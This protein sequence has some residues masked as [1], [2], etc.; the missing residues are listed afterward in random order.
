MND[1]LREELLSMQQEDQRLLKKLLDCGE[2]GETEYHPQMK[3]LHEKNN[4]R[5][6]AIISEHGWPGFSIVG[7]DG[8]KAAWLIVQ[9]AVL[10]K[11]F[12]ESTLPLLKQAVDKGEAE[13]WCLAYLQ[14]RVLTLSGKPQIYGSQHDFDENGMAYPLPIAEPEKVDTLRKGLGLG[15]LSEATKSI[16]ERYRPITD[17]HR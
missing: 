16:Q 11:A 5:I 15:P 10:D 1:L 13:G 9:H 4:R 7:K 3:V 2:L 6:K 12:M 14:D 8:S 17:N